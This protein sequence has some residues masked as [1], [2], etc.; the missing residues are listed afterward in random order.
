ME[1]QHK[2]FNFQC[3]TCASEGRNMDPDE[4][5]NPAINRGLCCARGLDEYDSQKKTEGKY[6][7]HQLPQSGPSS[8]T[9]GVAVSR[10][11]LHNPPR[12]PWPVSRTERP[13]PRL[14]RGPP[15]V[16][17]GNRGPRGPAGIRA[18]LGAPVIGRIASPG[19]M[20]DR[21][22]QMIQTN[23]GRYPPPGCPPR[24][25]LPQVPTDKAKGKQ[26]Q[27][28]CSI[29]GPEYLNQQ[30]P[31]R[32]SIPQLEA[33]R[34]SPFRVSGFEEHTEVRR[35]S[36]QAPPARYIPYRPDSQ[37]LVPQFPGARFTT[38]P[39][40]EP[41][42]PLRSV[43]SNLEEAIDGMVE[44]WTK[45]GGGGGAPSSEGNRKDGHS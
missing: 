24:K 41:A 31:N 3:S 2:R 5:G 14:S 6:D 9:D 22:A 21:W 44:L 12:T 35:E 4:R 11:L 45:E 30:H 15:E 10:S 26:V 39:S 25:P 42:R 32:N 37:I 16:Y 28:R 43:A 19:I 13:R 7:M 17:R 36:D 33:L 40:E 20:W 29:R 27:R 38:T 8:V 34:I 1:E 18:P 23:H